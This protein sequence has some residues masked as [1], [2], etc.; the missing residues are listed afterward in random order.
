MTEPLT[1][2]VRRAV[3]SDADG[4]S[5][6][7]ELTFPLACTPQTSDEFLA[8]HIAEHLA[9]SNFR[10]HLAD[11]ERV[12]LIAMSADL[13]DPVGYTMLASGRPADSDVLASLTLWPTV[14]LARCYVHPRA[15][16]T[17]VA[18]ELMTATLAAAH[19]L[20]AHGAW[21]G[22]SQ[23]NERANAFYAR[24]GFEVVGTKRF[25]IDETWEDDFVRECRLR[26][27]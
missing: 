27:G 9:P 22:V 21:L 23:E 14:E 10:D 15:H 25:H 26:V 8:K 19:E 11:P 5:R 4:L 2:E 6:L 12:V 20:G 17:G 24:H 13:A 18:N 16:G 1:A 3:A 7:A